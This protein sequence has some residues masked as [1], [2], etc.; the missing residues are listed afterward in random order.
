MF[1]SPVATIP[2]T[3]AEIEVF[4]AY[5]GVVKVGVGIRKLGRVVAAVAEKAE[6]KERTSSGVWDIMVLFCT[7]YRPIRGGSFVSIPKLL[8][9][10]EWRRGMK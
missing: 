10:G 4:S 5:G 3:L 7:E 1:A 8:E 9:R 6:I 2:P